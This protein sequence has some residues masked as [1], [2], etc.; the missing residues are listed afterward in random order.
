MGVTDQKAGRVRIDVP[1]GMNVYAWA[2]R[3]DGFSGDLELAAAH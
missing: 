3:V 1:M 2:V